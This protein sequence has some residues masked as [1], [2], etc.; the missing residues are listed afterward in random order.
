MGQ[1]DPVLAA[2]LWQDIVFQP[3]L[4]E[5]DP[6]E[7]SVSEEE[8]DGLEEARVAA[9]SGDTLA[10]LLEQQKALTEQIAKWREE[11]F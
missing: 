3:L 7:E 6:F 11:D 1:L 8:S 4:L 10:Q 2:V 9:M 5:E